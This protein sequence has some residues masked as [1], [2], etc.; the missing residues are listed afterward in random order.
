MTPP[1][2]S[3]LPAP[4][5]DAELPLPDRRA[6]KVRISYRYG[7]HHRLLVT[8]DRLSAFDRVI[9]G[10][11]YKGQVLNELSAFWF[12]ETADLVANH[13][14]E[15]I[16]PNAVVVMEANMLPVEVIVRR[17]ITGVTDTSLW[18]R[19]QHGQ[20]T[21]DGHRLPDGLAK[22]DLLPVPI[23]TPTTKAAG[24]GHDEPL[25]PAEV[26]TRGLVAADRWDEVVDAALAVFARGERLGERAGLTLA[27]TKY[28]F[29]IDPDGRI[30]LADEVH[31]PDSSRWW[32]T[33]SLDERR[34]RGE[35]PESL[36]KEVVRRALVDAG[37]RGDGDPPVLDETVWS[38]TSARY[39]DAFERL[40]GRT[41]VPGEYPV[42]PRLIARL[43]ERT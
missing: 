24:G 5:L 32:I 36:D 22:N 10:V 33:A 11:A 2:R 41:F 31:T 42:P 34:A 35:E 30:L 18:R 25:A 40:T 28:E 13:L 37:Y 9:A 27:D 4:F 38:H 19:Y 20:R 21:I 17:A 16:D 26:V 14:V 3:E 43:Q 7:D 12:G 6:G 23:V 29:G 1:D 15:V 8:T 39:V